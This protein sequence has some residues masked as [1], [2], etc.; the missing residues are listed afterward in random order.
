MFLDAAGNLYV[1]GTFGCVMN[2]YSSVYGAGIFNSI[3][4]RDI[5]LTCYSTDGI[6]Q[7]SRQCGGP[8]EDELNALTATN[9]G[10]PV[11]GGGFNI[12]FVYPSS[13]NFIHPDDNVT[14]VVLA[15]SQFNFCGDAEH[16][17]FKQYIS[18]GG[19][20]Y[21]FGKAFDTIRPPYDFYNR[22]DSNCT[23]PQIGVC[24]TDQQDDN[25]C[26]LRNQAGCGG[27]ELWAS[28]NTSSDNGNDTINS[29]GPSFNYLW[30][31]GAT[32]KN[33]T[34]TTSGTYSV[35]ITSKDG[36]LSSTAS[37]NVLAVVPPLQP[38]ITDNHGVNIN[39]YITNALHICFSDSILFTAGNFGNYAV[40]WVIGNT[41]NYQN[42][43]WFHPPHAGSFM[44]FVYAEDTINHCSTPNTVVVTVDSLL[45]PIDP[46]IN[47]L[48]TVTICN[49]YPILV[50][51]LDSLQP[52]PGQTCGSIGNATCTWAFTPNASSYSQCLNDQNIFFVPGPTGTYNLTC[53]IHRFTNCNNQVDSFIVNKTIYVVNQI[54]PLPN[55]IFATLGGKDSLCGN[56]TITIIASGAQNYSW[57]PGQYILVNDS[58]IQ[59]FSPGSYCVSC[60]NTDTTGCISSSNTCK[61][62]YT[63]TGLSISATPYDGLICPGDS[64][65]L[66]CDSSSTPF[67]WNGPNGS[68]TT[69]NASIG[70]NTPGVYNCVTTSASGCQYITNS[71]T[72]EQ[73]ST[74]QILV[75]PTTMLCPGSS[76]QL[77]ATAY[78]NSFFDWQFP[79]S[80]QNNIQVVDTPGTYSCLILSCGLITMA[81]VDVFESNVHSEL[82]PPTSN[83]TCFGDSL[84]LTNLHPEYDAVWLPGLQ[85]GDSIWIT[86]AGNFSLVSVDSSGC[87]DTSAVVQL[88]FTPAPAAPLLS[89][90]SP[91]C[92]GD[93]IIISSNAASGVQ[94]TW[95]GPAGYTSSNPQ[96]IIPG[97]TVNSSGTYQLQVKDGGCSS[98]PGAINIQVDPSPPPFTIVA[99]VPVCKGG[100]L[101]LSLSPSFSDTVNWYS[102]TNYYGPLHQFILQIPD[103][104]FT[105]YIVCEA[106]RDQCL[107]SDSLLITSIDCDI[108][109]PNVFTPNGDGTNET[110]GTTGIGVLLNELIIYNRWGAKM[111]VLHGAERWDGKSDGGKLAPE[112]VYYFT[113]TYPDGSS[114]VKA[115]SGYFELLR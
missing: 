2:Q 64:V 33:I 26:G 17:T 98:L 57:T 107:R 106:G 72:V 113:A 97:A 28:T 9:N 36:C 51:V 22:N 4:Y 48:D 59:V 29:P 84:L 19:E 100:E 87:A 21:F 16:G 43:I 105:G 14:P 74:P 42:S 58:T 12:K 54:T 56:D 52:I 70:V 49:S 80:G 88:N 91:L 39:A 35:T 7:W 67:I 55:P 73:Y 115:V 76:V 3:G 68:I 11:I 6:F 81:T 101:S 32:T 38:T 92:S 66:Q 61:S 47:V 95:T 62:I 109:F 31:T 79:L 30:S 24:I 108:S 89:A 111:A 18:N 114:G 53:I 103:T 41:Q 20:D 94:Y 34:A 65:I 46:F 71:I 40:D 99:D 104:G 37:L 112:G 23:R 8:Y 69:P 25:I 78:G 60:S 10:I 13:T 45:A 77:V 50:Q 63:S 86:Q 83:T 75:A 96:V 102:G 5:F 90:N 44:L 110:F 82:L 27:T 1:G 85:T 93:S 15:P